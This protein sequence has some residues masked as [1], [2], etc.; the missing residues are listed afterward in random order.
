MRPLWL[1]RQ[2]QRSH[3]QG[4]NL[5]PID[6]MEALKR[7]LGLQQATPANDTTTG[8][9]ALAKKPKPPVVGQREM[10]SSISG[11]ASSKAKAAISAKA[12]RKAG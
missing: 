10:L 6:L 4:S 9:P 12:G 3:R 11:G 8:K 1:P 5:R 2:R 7:S